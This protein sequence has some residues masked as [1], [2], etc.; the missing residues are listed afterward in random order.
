MQGRSSVRA[1]SLAA[2]ALVTLA[3]CASRPPLPPIPQSLVEAARVPGFAAVRQWGDDGRAFAGESAAAARDSGPRTPQDADPRTLKV[4]AISGGGANGAFAAGLLIG[5]T[6]AGTRPAFDV[7]TGVSAGALAAPFA[8]L[9][10]PKDDVLRR[11]FSRLSARD[12]IAPRTR[13]LAWFGDSLASAAPLQALIEEHFDDTLMRAIAGEHRKGRRLFV[14]TTHVYAG[15]PVIWDLGAIAAS[16][17]PEAL[18]LIRRVLLASASVPILLPPVYIEAEAGGAR[19][20]EM[21]VDGGITRQTFIAPPGFDW[22]ALARARG[23]S[24]RAEF[25]V[26]RNG[27]TRSEYMPMRPDIAALGEHAMHQ[28]TQSLGI[29]DLYT[30]Y[31][32]AEREGAGFFAAWIGEDFA[33]PWQGWFDPQYTQALFEYGHALALKGNGWHRMPPDMAAS[34]ASP[35]RAGGGN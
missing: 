8:F 23:T 10:A 20:S 15:R 11:L 14:S 3:A 18:A 28:L 31:L 12:V 4:L 1:L 19:Y 7:V 24:A 22:R 9:G 32:R 30:I 6:R 21:H 27:R 33:A 17:R 13:L 25:Y 34:P 5:W 16:G 35:P 29:G 2:A 26:I